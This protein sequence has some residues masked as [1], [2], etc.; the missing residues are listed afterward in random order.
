MPNPAGVSHTAGSQACFSVNLAPAETRLDRLAEEELAD[1]FGPVPYRVARQPSQLESE[2]SMQRV[3]REL[4]PVLIL[5]LAV[6]LGVEH[7]LANKFYR[8]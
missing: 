3:G 7:L 4:F 2:R 5:L 8:E 1:V 6:A